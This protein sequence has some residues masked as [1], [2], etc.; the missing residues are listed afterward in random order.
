MDQ[1]HRKRIMKFF[2]YL[3]FFLSVNIFLGFAGR[4][5]AASSY[6]FPAFN[7]GT[8]TGGGAAFAKPLDVSGVPPGEY[9]FVRVTAHYQSAP[10]P[11]DAYPSTLGMELSDGGTNVFWPAYPATVGAVDTDYTNTLVW[12]GLFPQKSYPGGTKLTLQFVDTYSD[13]N[14][15]YYSTIS[16]VVVTLFQSSTP[17]QNFAAF[18][19]GML[20][21]NGAAFTKSLDVSGL[22]PSEYLFARVT[23]NYQSAPQPHDAYPTTMDMELSDGGTNVFWPA[24]T[25]TVGP[26]N[27]DYDGTLCWCGVFPENSY[28]GGTNLTIQFMD[29]FNDANG[30]YY[31][32]MSNVVVSLYPA[33]TPSKTFATFDV[34]TLTGNGAAF[35]KS[36]DV[37]GL[38]PSE[39]LFARVTADY[40]SAPQPH[41]AYPNTMDMELS[42][43]GTNVFWP[44]FPATVGAVSTDYTNKL[45]WCGL[46]PEHSYPGGTNLTIQFRDTY[47]DASGPYYST[48]SNVVVTLYPAASVVVTP[49]QLAITRSGTNDILSWTNTATG[50]TLEST[51]NLIPPITW[52]TVSPAAVIVN[53][54][55]TVTNAVSP[56]P[57]FYRLRQ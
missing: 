18:D 5:E 12:C 37:S 47:N 53:G 56:A 41:D 7:V 27:M 11:N 29:T 44:A 2:K 40:Q 33:T 54:Q 3:P 10:P 6:T 39:Y 15:P 1:Q 21:G 26:V 9:L 45:I 38:P 16:N 25:A 48:M 4:G 8:L 20:T 42:D 36:L 28:P 57:E 55:F 52:S 23:A 19:V 30:P 24:D 31:S 50:F 35:T 34:G 22:P 46:F 32:T 17:A 43:G 51:T 13:T 49:P 14:G